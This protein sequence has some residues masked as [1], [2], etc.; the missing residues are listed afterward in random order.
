[1]R[2]NE[3]NK[4]IL[5][6][7]AKASFSLIIA[8]IVYGI[9]WFNIAAIFPLIALE[10][11]T[12]VSLL[13]FI[14][15]AFFMGVGLFQIP[16]GIF[17]AKYN[18]RISA[19]VGITISSTAALLCGLVLSSSELIWLRFIVGFGMAFFFSSAI[20][21]IARYGKRGFPG[22]S[23]G[24]M[25]SAHSMGGIIGIFAW[26]I[27]AQMV[28][29]RVSLMLS[30]VLGLVTALLMIM[31]IP[32]S[33]ITLEHDARMDKKDFQPAKIAEK[34]KISDALR[35][36]SNRTL[37]YLG[38]TLI[39]I[40]AAWAVELTFIVIYLE[41]LGF[42]AEL[43]G[44]IASLPLIFAIV[45]AP[46][47]GGLYDKVRDTR[48]VLLIC[49]VG[50]SMAM[51][52]LSFAS[53]YLIVTSV[54]FT[55]FFSGGAFTVVYERAR[56]VLI[57]GIPDHRNDTTTTATTTLEANRRNNTHNNKG[58]LLNY[59]YYYDTLKVA[60]VNGLSLIGV[61]WTPLVFSYIAEENSYELAW[62][63]SAL[64][65]ALLILV[66]ISKLSK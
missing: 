18:P 51:I 16:A 33:N 22:F 37:V 7:D 64:V 36:L 48:T 34:L 35:V 41:N 60:W 1:M 29:W 5:S 30:G 50:A 47:I 8:R 23:I 3:K 46:L 32:R 27:I 13:G 53:L 61:V 66:P 62:I 57:E 2:T 38:I 54:I 6:S 49:G 25:N 52:G 45:S 58:S 56:T 14:S 15:A 21:L 39:G 44:I 59:P 42:S 9:N 31:T 24:L 63:L 11:N 19:I 20:I 55:G 43:A 17:A 65:T 40:Q 26:I 28:G 10:F 4:V 12:D